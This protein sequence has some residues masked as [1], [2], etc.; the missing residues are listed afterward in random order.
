MNYD[1]SVVA[2]SP[3]TDHKGLVRPPPHHNLLIYNKLYL[4]VE[5]IYLYLLNSMIRPTNKILKVSY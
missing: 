4:Y 3:M 1:V 5:Q 2:L